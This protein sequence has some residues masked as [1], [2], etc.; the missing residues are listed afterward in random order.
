MKTSIKRGLVGREKKPPRN[1][2]RLA[3]IRGNWFFN[4]S[5]YDFQNNF[6]NLFAARRA[7]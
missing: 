1:E 4:V 6:F 2:I 5:P 3:F 7:T